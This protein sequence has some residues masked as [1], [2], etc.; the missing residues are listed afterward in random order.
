[1]GVSEA[2]EVGVCEAERSERERGAI[3][4]GGA[5]DLDCSIVDRGD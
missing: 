4:Q 2:S 5:L 3:G 1:V